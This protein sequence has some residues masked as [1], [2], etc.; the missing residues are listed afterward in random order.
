MKVILKEEVKK[1]GKSGQIVEV[2]SGYARNFLIPKKLVMEATSANLKHYEEYKKSQQ[3]KAD[4]E[5]QK[6]EELAKKMAHISCTI[7]MQAHDD[8][9]YG[10][11]TNADVAKALEQEGILIDKKDVLLDESIKEL[12]VFQVE[13]KLHPQ[14]KQQVKVWVVKK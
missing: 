14:V 8:Q 2:S 3:N 5:K 1:I 4:K 10:S 13:I 9:L 6:A 7:I 12:G 11:V